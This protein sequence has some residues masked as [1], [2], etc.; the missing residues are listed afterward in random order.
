MLRLPF[1]KF[2]S[3]LDNISFALSCYLLNKES[4]VSSQHYIYLYKDFKTIKCNVELAD[5]LYQEVEYYYKN[6]IQISKI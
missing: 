5:I 1:K 6:S 3:N 4:K 2:N